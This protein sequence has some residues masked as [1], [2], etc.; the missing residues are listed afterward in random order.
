MYLAGLVGF[1]AASLLCALAPTTGALVAARAVQ[2]VAAALLVPGSLSTAVGQ[3]PARGPQSRH[4]GMVG[5][6][7]AVDRRGPCSGPGSSQGPTPRP[8][9][10]VLPGLAGIG[11][12][13]ELTDG[14]RRAMLVSGALAVVEAVTGLVLGLIT[15]FFFLKDGPRLQ[16]WATLG[17]YLRGAALLGALEAATIGTALGLVGFA[18]T[19]LALP[20]TAVAVNVAAE[21]RAAERGEEETGDSQCIPRPCAACR[22]A[23]VTFYGAPS[24]ARAPAANVSTPVSSVGWSTGASADCG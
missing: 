16:S 2:G 4:W 1:A 11:G 6:G 14:F 10:A 23:R 5:P 22:R 17:G 20:V 3:L 9:L 12:G 15:T 21:A 7:R 18:R 13:A 24:Q 8:S 19:V